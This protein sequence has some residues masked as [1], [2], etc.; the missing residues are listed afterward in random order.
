[1]VPLNATIPA[2]QSYIA[3]SDTP[4]QSDFFWNNTIDDSTP[5]DWT[6]VVGKDTYYPIRYNHRLAFVKS[7]DVQVSTAVTSDDNNDQ[8]NDNS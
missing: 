1:V 6:L 8:G 2:G 4:V 5:N 3:A 7:T